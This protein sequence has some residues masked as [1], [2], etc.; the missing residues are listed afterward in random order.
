[1]TD[2]QVGEAHDEPQPRGPHDAAEHAEEEDRHRGQDQF[3]PEP[4]R[5]AERHRQAHEHHDHLVEAEAERLHEGGERPQQ[6][7]GEAD[8]GVVLVT[9]LV[10]PRSA[11]RLLD[12]PVG[13]AH[14]TGDEQDRHQ[15]VAL[16]GVERAPPDGCREKQVEEH[17]LQAV[18]GGGAPDDDGRRHRHG[19]QPHQPR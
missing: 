9:Q 1:M 19:E 3:G 15:P 8:G 4:T 7:S 18:D 11:E 10:E 13:G 17:D 5:L 12:Q 16:G 14:D 2:A 6:P